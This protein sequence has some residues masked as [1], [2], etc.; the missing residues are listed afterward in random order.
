MRRGRTDRNPVKRPLN[1]HHQ[2]NRHHKDHIPRIVVVVTKRPFL[3]TQMRHDAEV[4]QG[5]VLAQVLPDRKLKFEAFPGKI[6]AEVKGFT[7]AAK[8]YER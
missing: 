2:Q 5:T 6:A 8:I 1:G 7:S 3:P 4:V